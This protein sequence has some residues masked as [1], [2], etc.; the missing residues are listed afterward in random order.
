MSIR[1]EVTWKLKIFFSTRKKRI[2]FNF[3]KQ[4]KEKSDMIL[5]VS[6]N[7]RGKH[8]TFK[9]IPT[10]LMLDDYFRTQKS[11]KCKS[12]IIATKKSH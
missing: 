5:L 4:K 2:N 10:N 1:K 3:V 12:F 7:E 9:N 8:L 11:K 6:Y